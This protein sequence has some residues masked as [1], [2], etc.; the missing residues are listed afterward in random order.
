MLGK[1]M[2]RLSTTDLNLSRISIA[3]DATEAMQRAIYANWPP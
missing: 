1:I 3:A 2:N